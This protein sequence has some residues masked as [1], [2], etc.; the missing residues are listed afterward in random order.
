MSRERILGAVEALEK[1]SANPGFPTLAAN[2]VELWI[3]WTHEVIAAL[4]PEPESWTPEFEDADVQT[5]YRLL[6]D[7]EVPPSGDH[8]EGFAA[9]RIVAALRKPEPWTPRERRIKVVL[10]N[11][12]HGDPHA[13]E[14]LEEIEDL[15]ADTPPPDPRDEVLER[16]EK[17]LEKVESYLNRVNHVHLLDGSI[18]YA[19]EVFDALA[20]IRAARGTK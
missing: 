15:F 18:L 14:A 12:R 19:S 5:V 1:I 9:Q 4:P 20:A 2:L 8:W 16:A 10:T 17:T 6:C 3:T 13:A 7:S 11:W